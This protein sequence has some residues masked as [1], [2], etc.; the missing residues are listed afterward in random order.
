MVIYC[1]KRF[2]KLRQNLIE[3]LNLTEC[4]LLL[5]SLPDDKCQHKVLSLQ[6]SNLNQASH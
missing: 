2:S 4:D 6:V 1:N 5:N 3:R